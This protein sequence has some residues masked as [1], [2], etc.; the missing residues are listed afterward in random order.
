M[1]KQLLLLGFLLLSI[2]SFGQLGFSVGYRNT[3]GNINA[4]YPNAD[5]NIKIKSFKGFSAFVTH[6]TEVNESMDVRPELGLDG[7][8]FD[9][10]MYKALRVNLPFLYHLVDEKL[11]LQFG[12]NTGV[13][14]EKPVKDYSNLFVGMIL[15]LSY[16]LSNNA[17][18]QVRYFPELTNEYLGEENL[19]VKD[20][21]LIFSV[22]YTF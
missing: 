6:K 2:S 4:T 17:F 7:L 20:N 9:K 12:V 16:N 22:G 15:G 5:I 10:T 21:S 14:L 1:K 19:T 3:N 11:D 18:V 8:F 13:V